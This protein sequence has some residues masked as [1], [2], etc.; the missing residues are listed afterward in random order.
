MMPLSRREV[1]KLAGVAGASRLIGGRLSRVTWASDAYSSVVLAKGPVGYW[2]LSETDGPTAVDS[3]GRGYDGIYSGNPTFGQSGAITYAPDTAVGF[4][5]PS[6]MDYVEIAEPV[7][8]SQAFSQPTS[9]AGLTVEAWMR[10]DVLSFAGETP[11]VYIHWVGKCVSGSGQCE[12]GFRF[13]SRDSITRPNRISA[14][15]WNP[16]G[17]EG[18]GAYF[19]D[20][21]IAGAWIHIVAVY[22]PGDMNSDPPAGVHI[23]KNGVHRHGPPSPGSLYRTYSIL[24]ANGNLPVRLGTRDAAISG[25][26]SVSYLTG[27]IDEVAVYPRVLSGDEILENYTTATSIA[28]RTY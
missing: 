28:A 15:I 8:G 14:Y 17:G 24:P 5:G 2:R 13:Y 27:G 1:L 3:S 10:P 21:L 11:D 18:A 23:Y 12:W 20:E 25:D 6:S 19:Q 4:N 26:A 22:E 7:D 9:G 16:D